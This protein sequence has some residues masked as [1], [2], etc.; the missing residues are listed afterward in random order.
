[1]I[2][3][4]AFAVTKLFT[5]FSLAKASCVCLDMIAARNERSAVTGF[6]AIVFLAAL[7]P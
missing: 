4:T 5:L 2:L 3:D 6:V 1:M 7:L